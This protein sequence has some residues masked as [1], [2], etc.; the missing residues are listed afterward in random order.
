MR[1]SL[2]GALSALAIL[3]ALA[4]TPEGTPTGICWTVDRLE[5][6]TLVV[7]TS[8]GQSAPV[9][10]AADFAVNGVEKRSLSEGGRLHRLDLGPRAAWQAVGP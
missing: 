2:M 4:Q 8:S 3:P 1:S 7:K 9:T 10:M 6:Q 5:G